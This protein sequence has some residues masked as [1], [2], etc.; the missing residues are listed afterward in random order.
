MSYQYGL[1]NTPYVVPFPF[2]FV[3]KKYHLTLIENYLILK[4]D[5][6]LPLIK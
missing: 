3:Q 2:K 5:F 4:F 6:L 1:S